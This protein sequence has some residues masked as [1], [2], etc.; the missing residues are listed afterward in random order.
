MICG[1][2]LMQHTGL[3]QCNHSYIEEDCCLY[4]LTN[5]RVASLSVANVAVF[6][7]GAACHREPQS[8]IRT[9]LIHQVFF[10]KDSIYYFPEYISNHSAGGR[11]VWVSNNL[12][13]FESLELP[14][15]VL[16]RINSLVVFAIG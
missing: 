15:F 6:P 9:R 5:S 1:L 13:L 12:D 8:S 7:S 11:G 10:F 4:L 14:R 3:N 2:L 16:L